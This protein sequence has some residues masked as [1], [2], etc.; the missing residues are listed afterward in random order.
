M[1]V[2][3]Y[4][5]NERYVRRDGESLKI[6]ME[7]STIDQV[8]AAATTTTAM[9]FITSFGIVRISFALSLRLAVQDQ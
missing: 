7:I 8:A 4:S 1:G 5:L 6:N 3:K 9:T 2:L